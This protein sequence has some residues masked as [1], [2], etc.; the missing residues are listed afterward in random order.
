VRRQD[1]I[2]PGRYVLLTVSDSGQGIDSETVKKIFDPFFTTKEQGKG[3]GLG[4]STVYGIVKQHSGS[5]EVESRPGAGTRFNIYFPRT[6][7]ASGAA[8]PSETENPAGGMETVLLVEDEAPIRTMLS[9]HLRALGY[10]VLEADDGVSALRVL[11]EQAG[12]L[13]ILVT[14]V[15]M[16][17]MNGMDLRDQLRAQVPGLKVLFMSGY[18]REVISSHTE[19]DEEMDLMTKPFTGQA[20]ASRVREVL[21]RR[22]G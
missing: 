18:P 2:A 5:I 4:L 6:E 9:R 22:Q 15:V 17:R 11:A 1:D 10:T 7:A 3:T 20:L 21:D 12:K 13:H 14:D 16:P 19:A 8:Q